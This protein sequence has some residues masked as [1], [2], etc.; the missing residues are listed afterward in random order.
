MNLNPYVVFDHVLVDFLEPQD[1]IR[2]D[3]EVYEVI[4]SIA[5]P[6]GFIIKAL[7]EFEE[8][9]DLIIPDNTI[10]PLLEED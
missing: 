8:V 5:M 3:G 1:L 9:V 7:D 2:W 10:I 6:D 4:D